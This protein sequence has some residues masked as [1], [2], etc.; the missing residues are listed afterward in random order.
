MADGNIRIAGGAGIQCGLSNGDVFKAGRDRGQSAGTYG[1]IR[2]YSCRAVVPIQIE[3]AK[4]KRCCD[5]SSRKA[6]IVSSIN[7]IKEPTAIISI[8]GKWISQGGRRVGI[9]GI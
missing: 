5:P 6:N 9:I 3:I 7:G 1:D 8:G 2:G 4:S